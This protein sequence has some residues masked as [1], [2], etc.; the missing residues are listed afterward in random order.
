[1][2][3]LFNSIFNNATASAEPFQLLLA[4]LV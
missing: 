1:M 2:L 3:N 4:L